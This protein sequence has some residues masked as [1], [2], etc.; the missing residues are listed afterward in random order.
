MQIQVLIVPSS[1]LLPEVSKISYVAETQG[2][3]SNAFVTDARTSFINHQGHRKIHGE[4]FKYTRSKYPLVYRQKRMLHHAKKKS[5]RLETLG[6][7]ASAWH[8]RKK[9]SS[10]QVLLYKYRDNGSD[11]SS[12]SRDAVKGQ[13]SSRLLSYLKQRLFMLYVLGS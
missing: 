12:C 9:T 5:R 7:P 4:C 10:K 2:Q 13:T 6:Y 11:P 3:K 1:N 8:L